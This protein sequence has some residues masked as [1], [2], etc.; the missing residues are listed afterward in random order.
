MYT[1]KNTTVTISNLLLNTPLEI[2]MIAIKL[3]STAGEEEE[4]DT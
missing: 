3:L 2:N 4:V 1:Y